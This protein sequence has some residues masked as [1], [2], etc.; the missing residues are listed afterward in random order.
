MALKVGVRSGDFPFPAENK[1]FSEKHE[2]FAPTTFLPLQ[3]PQNWIRL[4]LADI[5]ITRRVRRW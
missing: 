4:T 3:T 5:R 1:P 2:F